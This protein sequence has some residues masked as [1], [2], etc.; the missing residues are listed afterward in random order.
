MGLKHLGKVVGGTRIDPLGQWVDFFQLIR[1][2][3]GKAS[4]E[5][6][7]WVISRAV[8][9]VGAAQ[10]TFHPL[11]RGV[12]VQ[13]QVHPVAGKVGLSNRI[14][15][16]AVGMIADIL[17]AA[18]L[19]IRLHGIGNLIH[20]VFFTAGVLIKVKLLCGGTEVNFW[21]GKHPFV[22]FSLTEYAAQRKKV[23]KGQTDLVWK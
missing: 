8:E 3:V 13:S 1:C 10:Q 6:S 14:H 9:D 21:Q 23:N 7:V 20:P 4:A 15:H 18:G 17:D 12:G 19:Q 22:S 11:G 2:D 16:R 5:Q